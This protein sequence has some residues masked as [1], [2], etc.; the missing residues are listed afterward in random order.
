MKNNPY[1]IDP[2]I[3]HYGVYKYGP[4]DQDQEETSDEDIAGQFARSYKTTYEFLMIRETLMISFQSLSRISKQFIFLMK[5]IL[6]VKLNALQQLLVSF[7]IF[8]FQQLSIKNNYNLVFSSEESINYWC[9]ASSS[10]ICCWIIWD[11][12]WF[13][14]FTSLHHSFNLAV[15]VST[16]S[17]SSSETSAHGGLSTGDGPNCTFKL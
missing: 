3:Y 8:N 2:L 15:A 7:L 4:D 14:F 1:F 10:L 13:C 12:C 5:Q 9:R 16:F 17:T 11:F 6:V